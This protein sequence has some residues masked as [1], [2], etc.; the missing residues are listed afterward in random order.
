MIID[1]AYLKNFPYRKRSDLHWERK[2][3]HIVSVFGMFLVYVWTP[4]HVS[5]IILLAAIAFFVPFDLL[6]QRYK[7]L[8]EFALHLFRPIIRDSEIHRFAGTTYLLLG[9]GAIHLLFSRDVVSLTLLFLAFAD[10]LAS[11]IGIR[12]GKD[13]IFGHKSVQG[14]LAAYTV[15]FICTVSYL[16]VLNLAWDRVLFFSILAALVGALSELVPIGKLDD[17][18]TLPVLS[19][20]GLSLLFHL[21]QF[22]NP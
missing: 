13:K 21:F 2:I 10:P 19:A 17:N 1:N 9:V 15:C 5:R 12:Y 22:T 14:F 20:L 11:F 3:W 8:N 6:R 7:G 18:L 16:F 4:L